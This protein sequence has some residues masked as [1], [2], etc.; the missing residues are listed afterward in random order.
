ML[1]MRRVAHLP[2]DEPHFAHAR[3]CSLGLPW[4]H[5]RSGPVLECPHASSQSPV[6]TPLDEFGRVRCCSLSSC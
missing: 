5:V 1:V 6:H 4:S 2:K 3:R